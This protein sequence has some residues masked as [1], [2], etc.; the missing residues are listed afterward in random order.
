MTPIDPSIPTVT[1]PALK[2]AGMRS[3]DHGH[4]WHVAVN[5]FASGKAGTDDW[6]KFMYE[7]MH[8]A[9]EA[10]RL[11][12]LFESEREGKLPKIHC[13]CPT[14][15]PQAVPIH[16]NHLTCCLGVECRKCP[17]LLALD[18]AGLPPQ[19][20]DQAKAWTC[21]A[22]IISKGGDWANEGYILT[23]DD[24]MFWDRVYDNLAAPQSEE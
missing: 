22:H 4:M 16:D 8:L 19:A 15:A 5:Q 9:E 2:G 1:I 24:R 13:Q 20:L 23:T 21:C 6:P 7:A 12:Y 14:C 11:R 18:S 3:S 17:H 10:V